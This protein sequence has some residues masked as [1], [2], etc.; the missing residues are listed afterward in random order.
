[1]S[2]RRV[3]TA[4]GECWFYGKDSYI[5]KSLYHYGEW[6]GEECTKI[7]SLCGDVNLDVGANIGYFSM[8]MPGTVVAFEPQPNL[9]DLLKKNVAG[10]NVACLPYALSD[11][12]R[13]APMARVRYGDT[14]NYGGIGLD[15]TSSLGSIKVQCVT[16]DSLG[17][18]PDFIKI[19]VEGHELSVLKGA[20]DTIN[21]CSPI[22]YVEDDR[23]DKRYEL[24]KYIE[25]LGYKITEHNPP[26]YRPN[27][28]SGLQKNVFDKY[29]IS[30]NII[31]S[32]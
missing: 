22:L 20:A 5:G 14:Y 19:D 26:M 28:F 30:K 18:K 15:T 3:N 9:F 12:Y 25:Y 6:S 32:K 21:E 10:K 2:I 11:S 13:I 7:V 24:R 31:C 16:L 27:N 17:L 4:Y 29:Y 1:M 23:D 8:A